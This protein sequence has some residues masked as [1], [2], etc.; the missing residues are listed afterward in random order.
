MVKAVVLT[1]PNR[2]IE[3]R[4]FPKPQNIEPGAALLKV[5]MAGICGTDIHLWHGRLK[6]PYP[7]IPGHEIVGTL[8]KI[9]EGLDKDLLG[10]PLQEGDRVYFA[11][12]IDCG[13]CYYCQ[14]AK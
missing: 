13:R 8:E 3:V 6:I 7:V 4:D 9:G 14:I 12:G 10:K 11:S 1:A 2:P 5:E